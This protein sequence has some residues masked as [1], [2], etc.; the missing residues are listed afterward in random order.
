MKLYNK[1]GQ[2]IGELYQSE[3]PN[4]NI[5]L[6]I[7]KLKDIFY[8]ADDESIYEFYN[9]FNKYARQF[10][11]TTEFHENAFLA[12]IVAETGYALKSV[13]ENLNYTPSA[14]R[15]TFSRYSDNPDWSERDGRTDAHPAN[16]IQ[17]GN[18][19]YADRLGNG[20][21]ESGDG[22]LFRGGGYF[23]LTGRSHYTKMATAINNILG[24]NLITAEYI[25][26]KIINIPMGTL[27]AMAFWLDNECSECSHID[28][29]TEKINYYTDSYQ[30]RKEIYQWITEV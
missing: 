26:E 15:S 28:C 21:I 3:S 23:Q 18:V 20:D 27:T 9:I 2:N 16:Q 1:F 4:Q 7:K 5:Y 11:I 8:E 6:S 14:L 25:S 29:I 17:I 19:A 30:K 22:Y 13:R 24:D 12:Q 10:E